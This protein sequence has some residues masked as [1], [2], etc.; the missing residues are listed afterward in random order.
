M[1]APLYP[2]REPAPAIPADDIRRR[3][4]SRG[5]TTTDA[6][7][8]LARGNTYTILVSAR[9]PPAATA[10][11]DMYVPPGGGPPPHRH[12][13]EEMFSVL[14]GEIEITCRGVVAVARAGE[15][16]NVPANAPHAFR[17]ASSRPTRM[18]CMGA[19]AGL[20]RFLAEVGDA[21]ESRTAPAPLL[22]AAQ[23]AA[24]KAK[25]EA[26]APAYRTELLEPEPP[27]AA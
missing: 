11:I 21:V 6:A 13:F 16:V 23:Q 26:L 4:R 1:T 5:R 14:E 15:T 19:P 2:R 17:N 25:A 8:H 10:F 7:P 12:D 3:S 18:L 27:T 22:S 24:Q 20:D 9:T